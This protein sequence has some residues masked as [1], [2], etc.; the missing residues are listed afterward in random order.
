MELCSSRHSVY[1]TVLRLNH[2]S[3][4]RISIRAYIIHNNINN[5][6][7]ILFGNIILADYLVPIHYFVAPVHHNLDECLTWVAG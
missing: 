4:F 5:N 1:I 2:E 3:R 6:I 7:I